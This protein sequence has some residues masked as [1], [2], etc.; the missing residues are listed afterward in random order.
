LYL[1]PLQATPGR[2]AFGYY[3]KGDAP[4]GMNVI[5]LNQRGPGIGCFQGSAC[6][7]A[8]NGAPLFAINAT[9]DLHD[10]LFQK[11]ILPFNILTNYPTMIPAFAYTQG[12]L[13][14]GD[15]SGIAEMISR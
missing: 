4:L 5:G 10:D 13:M 8:L 3:Y 14:G 11:Q 12:A 15:Y 1:V 2:N 6:S 9:A 7:Q